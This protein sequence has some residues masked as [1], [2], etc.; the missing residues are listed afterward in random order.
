MTTDEPTPEPS[1]DELDPG[2]DAYTSSRVFD[3]GLEI[4]EARERDRAERLNTIALRALDERDR[5]QS[6]AIVLAIIL[7]AKL[8]EELLAPPVDDPY[9]ARRGLANVLRYGSVYE[10]T[11][12]PAGARTMDAE[13]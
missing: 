1:D 5:W 13:L 4:G 8:L 12:A 6:I 3:V 11:G 10:P 7:A 2:P 9:T